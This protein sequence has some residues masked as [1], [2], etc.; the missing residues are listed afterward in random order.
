MA[1]KTT[2]AKAEEKFS[3]GAE[4]YYHRNGIFLSPSDKYVYEMNVYEFMDSGVCLADSKQTSVKEFKG[5]GTSE[6]IKKND[7]Q[8]LKSVELVSAPITFLVDNN[9][10]LIKNE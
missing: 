7:K 2:K 9:F 10:K 1:K 8:Y 3:K 5:Y 4:G 6:T